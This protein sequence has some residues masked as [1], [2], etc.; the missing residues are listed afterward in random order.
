MRQNIEVPGSSGTHRK[1]TAYTRNKT[2]SNR[3]RFLT[4]TWLSPLIPEGDKQKD[5]DYL[6]DAALSGSALCIQPY[7]SQYFLSFTPVNER[8]H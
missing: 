6:G 7:L 3:V 4:L 5:V 8:S 1:I 2:V